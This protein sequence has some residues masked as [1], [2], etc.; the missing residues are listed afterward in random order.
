M[1]Q[2]T[3]LSEKCLMKGFLYQGVDGTPKRTGRP[4]VTALCFER[5]FRSSL[6]LT[7]FCTQFGG[8]CV[9]TQDLALLFT[10]I[11]MV[12]LKF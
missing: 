11:V 3:E 2:K 4:S 12:M 7:N 6:Q 9:P 8:A 5:S 10:G 1:S